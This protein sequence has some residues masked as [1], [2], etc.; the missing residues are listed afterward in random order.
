MNTTDKYNSDEYLRMLERLEAAVADYP[1]DMVMLA[2]SECMARVLAATAPDAAAVR[3]AIETI[4]P[5]ALRCY[6][7]IARRLHLESQ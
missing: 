1:G 6:P 3:Y 4:I 2:L 7:D 5:K